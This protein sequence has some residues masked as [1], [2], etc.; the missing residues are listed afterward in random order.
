ML[1]ARALFSECKVSLKANKLVFKESTQST[2]V[3]EDRE[4]ETSFYVAMARPLGDRIV[5]ITCCDIV[6]VLYFIYL[7]S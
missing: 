3:N 5:M 6:I 1:C 4:S 7:G 2:G